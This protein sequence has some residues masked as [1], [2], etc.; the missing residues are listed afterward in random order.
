MHMA[1]VRHIG[2]RL[3]SDFQYG[4]GVI[5]NTFPMPLISAAKQKRLNLFAKAV[6]DARVA[7]P[8]ASLADLYDPDVMPGNLRKAHRV[9]DRAVDRPQRRQV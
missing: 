9:L 1:W 6:L 7:H 2:G 4:I 5:Y 3:K 8:G